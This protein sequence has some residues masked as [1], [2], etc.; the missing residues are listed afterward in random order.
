MTSATLFEG[1][2]AG[3]GDQAD[4]RPADRDEDV[5]IGGRVDTCVAVVGGGTAGIAAAAA[6]RRSLPASDRI[7]LIEP[8]ARHYYQPG[9]TLVGG[10]VWRAGQTSCPQSEVIPP[11]V[12]WLQTRVSAYEP[13]HDRLQLADGRSVAYGYLVSSPGL[14]LEWDRIPGL[15]DALGDGRVG[16]IYSLSTA[17]DTWARIRAFRGGRA[18]FTQPPMP[19]KC[20]GAPQKVVYMAADYWRRQGVLGD[21]TLRFR[22]ATPGLFSVTEYVPTLEAVCRRYGIGVGYGARL[23]S[24]DGPRAIAT[25]ERQSADGATARWEERYDLLHAVPPQGPTAAARIST[26][27]DADGWLDVD[28]ETLQHRRYRNVFGMGDATSVPTSKTAAAVRAQL[29]VVV[30]NLLAVM[31]ARTPAMHYSGYASCPLITAYGKVVLA[32]F[33]Y[34]RKVEPSLP[35]DST[36]ERRSAWWLKTKLLPW[37]YWQRLLRGRDL[38]LVARN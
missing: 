31:A 5:S 33:V 15:T 7:V 3:M 32:E 10:G 14:E 19:I 28:P 16:S 8:N 29:P 24:V 22:T 4:G 11:G 36:R 6:L 27:A 23:V 18:L 35:W 2:H 1:R 26:L 20:P 17:T 30:A 9:F 12:T 34:G 38:P 21:T 37:M 13:E 25:F